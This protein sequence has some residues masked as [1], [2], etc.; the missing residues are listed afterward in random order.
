MRLQ[1]CSFFWSRVWH[2][3]TLPVSWYWSPLFYRSVYKAESG[4]A[5]MSVHA[6]LCLLLPHLLKQLSKQRYS[7][8][9]TPSLRL[10]VWI[11]CWAQLRSLLATWKKSRI[12]TLNS[13]L[14][15]VHIVKKNSL[16]FH[17]TDAEGRACFKLL[18]CRLQ[19]QAGRSVVV[20]KRGQSVARLQRVNWQ[21]G[22]RCGQ[23]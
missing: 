10:T 20:A 15:I 7:S 14:I 12:A 22:E 2:H 4:C 13:F 1:R 21:N 17:Q 19:R 5:G 18:I 6:N 16:N 11:A 23:V 8:E 3:T 9:K